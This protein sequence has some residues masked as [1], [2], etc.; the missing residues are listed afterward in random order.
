MSGII[1]NYSWVKDSLLCEIFVV[2]GKM[3]VVGSFKYSPFSFEKGSGICL[4]VQ[5]NEESSAKIPSPTAPPFPLDELAWHVPPDKFSVR[6]TRLISY[7][8]AG[9]HCNSL[10]QQVY[11]I[12]EILANQLQISVTGT[13]V[14]SIFG[15]AG[16]RS[17]GMICEYLHQL[18]SSHALHPG[19][20]RLVSEDLEAELVR[21]CL[22][23]QHDKAPVTV[24]DMINLLAVQDVSV[25]RFWVRNFVMRHKEQLGFQKA[26]VLEKDRHDVSPN[27]ARS[28]FDT[29]AGKLTAFPSPF[30]WNVY[31]TRVGCPKRIAHSEVIVATNTKPGSVT[32]PEER[33]DA[34]LTLLTAISAFGDSICP[35]F[36]SKLKTFEKAILAAQKVY[37]GHDCAIRSAPRAFITEVLFI[38]WLDTIFLPR[39]S[40]LRRKFN[41][42]GPNILIVDGHSTHVTPRVI[43]LCGT[44]NVIMTRLIASRAATRL[45]RF[46]II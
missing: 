22:T 33:N 2:D 37:E 17:R 13:E 12:S 41:Y 43:A 23:C 8:I 36:I 3:I 30:V 39:I 20:S 34:Q 27:E 9:L 14:S 45:V 10:R 40:D 29:V 16:S 31:E 5:N 35:L 44:R 7:H 19:R 4:F 28:Y 25:D 18:S 42:D 26:R 6:T 1:S 38:G 11:K 32:V 15:R 24:S 46:R 21:F